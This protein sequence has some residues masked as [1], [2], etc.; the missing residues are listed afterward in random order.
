MFAI[1]H[2]QK[3]EDQNFPKLTGNIQITDGKVTALDSVEIAVHQGAT[4][5]IDDNGNLASIWAT[6]LLTSEQLAEGLQ[7]YAECQK[8]LFSGETK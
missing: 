8:E 6:F 5:N 7:F 1:I 2:L 4:L 3:S